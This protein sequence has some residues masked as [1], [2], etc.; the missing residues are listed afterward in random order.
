MSSD[1]SRCSFGRSFLSVSSG[2]GPRIRLT[3][4]TAVIDA[5][6]VNISA[7]DAP[8]VELPDQTFLVPGAT[9]DEAWTQAMDAVIHMRAEY[10]AAPM[11][12]SLRRRASRF[13]ISR[14]TS[15][16]PSRSTHRRSFG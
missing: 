3:S 12:N 15:Q 1:N 6:G 5:N 4:T 13:Q 8:R 11:F 10:D 7:F 14:R 9:F 16:D 2:D